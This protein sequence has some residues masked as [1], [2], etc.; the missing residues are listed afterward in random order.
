MTEID[1]IHV[2]S[3]RALHVWVI[4]QRPRALYLTCEYLALNEFIEGSLRVFNS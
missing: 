1:H 4:V 3:S 2:R